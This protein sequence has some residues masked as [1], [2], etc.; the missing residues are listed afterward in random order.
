MRVRQAGFPSIFPSTLQLTNLTG[1][2]SVTGTISIVGDPAYAGVV[3]IDHILYPTLATRAEDPA[4]T[5]PTRHVR[6]RRRGQEGDAAVLD[7][8][9]DRGDGRVSGVLE[10]SLTGANGRKS[11]TPVPFTFNLAKPIST[12]TR[13]TLFLL[14]LLAGVGTPILFLYY[15]AYRSAAIDIPPGL[16]APGSGSS[17]RRRQHSAACSFGATPPLTLVERDFAGC[18]DRTGAGPVARM[19]GPRALR[20]PPA[21]TR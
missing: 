10:L 19:A 21:R 12:G 18:R 13:N 1:L 20:A 4:R 16:R 5:D 3:C 7:P 9:R 6:S 11:V 2:G 8:R 15:F 17:V 14:L